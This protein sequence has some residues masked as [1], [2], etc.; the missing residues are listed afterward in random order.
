MRAS[1]HGEPATQPEPT[2]PRFGRGTATAAAEAGAAAGDTAGVT[3]GD[4]DHVGEALA[5]AP[6]LRDGVGVDDATA[7]AEGS[8][9]VLL[10]ADAD[11]TGNCGDGEAADDD[12]TS[13]PPSL[14]PPRSTDT[15]TTGS[16]DSAL[17]LTP[18]A[19]AS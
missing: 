19:D 1:V 5:L 18:A 4:S 12:D 14:F 8:G 16:S 9:G 10:V 7:E 6:T 11:A 15:T 3:E 2:K 17:T 13:A